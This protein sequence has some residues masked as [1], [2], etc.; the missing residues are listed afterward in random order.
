MAWAMSCNS[1]YIWPLSELGVIEMNQTLSQSSRSS[2]ES[3]E[4]GLSYALTPTI[5]LPGEQGRQSTNILHISLFPETNSAIK[6]WGDSG[7]WWALIIFSWS[8]FTQHCS[9]IMGKA[10]PLS[11]APAS[12]DRCVWTHVYVLKHICVMCRVCVC[13]YVYKVH[14]SKN[15]H[16][17]MCWCWCLYDIIDINMS[18]SI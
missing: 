18:T 11:S 12:K 14:Q 2:P 17:C 4:S 10:L 8:S 7:L 5:F 6:K 9:G 1:A 16:S 3:E 15:I 13:A